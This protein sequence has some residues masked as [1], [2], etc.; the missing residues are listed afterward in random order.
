VNTTISSAP[1]RC[2]ISAAAFTCS[3]MP[4]KFGDCTITA[5]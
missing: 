1:C 3:T 4:K 2:A 5:R